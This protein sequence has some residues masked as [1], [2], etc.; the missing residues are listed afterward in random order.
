MAMQ[1][2]EEYP[3]V[4]RCDGLRARPSRV[5]PMENG[6]WQ[7]DWTGGLVS[8][9]RADP[10]RDLKRGFEPGHLRWW[11]PPPQPNQKRGSHPT[12]GLGR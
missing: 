12:A 10:S 4:L 5:L 7:V 3:V 9:Y 2:F 6:L 8:V 1:P 11:R